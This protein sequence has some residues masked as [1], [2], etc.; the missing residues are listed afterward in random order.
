MDPSLLDRY[1]AG[2]VTADESRLVEAWMETNPAHRAQVESLRDM[3]RA[4]RD[5]GAR[6]DGA[7]AMAALRERMRE[8]PVLAIDQA[9]RKRWRM[10]ATLAA[11]LLVGVGISVGIFQSRDRQYATGPEGRL[12]VT[13]ADGSRVTLAPATTLRVSRS[14]RD[15]ELTGEAYFVVRH[16]PAHPLIVRTSQGAIQD[17]GTE[18]DVRAVAG[19][20]LRVAVVVGAVTVRGAPVDAGQV[21]TLDAVGHLARTRGRIDF[22]DATVGEAVRAIQQWTDERLVVDSELAGRHIT[23]SFDQETAADAM[24]IVAKLIDAHVATSAGTMRLV[25]K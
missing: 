20:P 13:L 7:L 2:Q 23:V 15:V 5:H 8:T 17:V 18:F 24:R 19:Q 11:A 21:A 12:S 3:R 14:H 22:R 4:L 9:R 10:P 16:D 1:V 25:P 6:Y